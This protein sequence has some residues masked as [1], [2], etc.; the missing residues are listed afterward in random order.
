MSNI[1]GGIALNNDYFITTNIGGTYY[2]LAYYDDD[3]D[4]NNKILKYQFVTKEDKEN[5]FAY[6]VTT[7]SSTGGV[8]IKDVVNGG[9]LTPDK[10]NKYINSKS[11]TTVKYSQDK[12]SE[13][14]GYIFLSNVDYKTDGSFRVSGKSEVN[15]N[16][17]FIPIVQYYSC[18][19]NSN[20]HQGSANASQALNNWILATTTSQA[21]SNKGWTNFNDCK[22]GVMYDYCLTGNLCGKDNCNGNCSNTGYYCDYKDP[23]YYCG[24]D[25]AQYLTTQKWWKSKWF[26]ISVAF[27]I[28]AAIAVSLIIV[29]VVYNKKKKKSADSATKEK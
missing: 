7:T 27:I 26:I 2:F 6:F 20:T 4:P 8:I 25:P 24:I 16:I 18:P 21:I 1:I 3:S 5:K 9:G 28:I 23:N 29:F 12:Y 11:P 22:I 17:N 19:K 14:N 15:K 10:D 13:W